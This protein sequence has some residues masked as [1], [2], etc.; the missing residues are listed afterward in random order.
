M[1]LCDRTIDHVVA[2]VIVRESYDR[3]RVLRERSLDRMLNHSIMKYE[4]M[5]RW[6]EIQEVLES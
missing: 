2:S 4:V 5:P 1:T 6:P 3:E